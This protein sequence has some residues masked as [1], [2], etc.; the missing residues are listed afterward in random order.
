MVGIFCRCVR[1]G[2][3]PGCSGCAHAGEPSHG[4]RHSVEFRAA[5]R[6]WLDRQLGPP[7][8][9]EPETIGSDS[10]PT[11]RHLTYKQSPEMIDTKRMMELEDDPERVTSGEATMHCEEPRTSSTQVKHTAEELDEP[12]AMVE[13]LEILNA[14]AEDDDQ[15][16]IMLENG[17]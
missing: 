11:R 7:E 8:A 6:R 17:E 4:I 15:T 14:D 9:I 3:T 16:Y 10:L 2:L 12:D 1:K 13:F 5:K